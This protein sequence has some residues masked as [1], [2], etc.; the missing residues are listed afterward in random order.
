MASVNGLPPLG[1]LIAREEMTGTFRRGA[2]FSLCVDGFTL[3]TPTGGGFTRNQ[4]AR[5]DAEGDGHLVFEFVK[6]LRAD[7]VPLA[8]FG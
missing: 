1:F 4:N 7:S 8:E 3:R 2:G 6:K 5:S